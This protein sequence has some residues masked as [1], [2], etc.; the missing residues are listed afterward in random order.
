MAVRSA[1]VEFVQAPVRSELAAAPAP[2]SSAGVR[3]DKARR[4]NVRRAGYSIIARILAER[5][6]MAKGLVIISMPSPR[7]SPR[8]AAP[9]A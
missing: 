6:S 5:A 7:N 4:A 1:S 2:A 9:S 3:F 8:T